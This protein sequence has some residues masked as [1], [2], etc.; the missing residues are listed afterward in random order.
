ME[1][2]RLREKVTKKDFCA[3]IQNY[4][5][6]VT[7]KRWNQEDASL[8]YDAFVN[9]LKALTAAY[10]KV[11]IEGLGN[12]EVV[13][14]NGKKVCNNFGV[15]TKHETDGNMISVPGCQIVRFNVAEVFKKEI[16][17][18]NHKFIDSEEG[19]D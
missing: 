15:S 5:Y 14:R 8:A 11:V 10:G 6:S 2:T 4:T 3:T 7:G 13:F 1:E 19:E 16:K 18:L 9:S 17:N 12:F